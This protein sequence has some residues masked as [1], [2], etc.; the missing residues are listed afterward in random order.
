MKVVHFHAGRAS[1]GSTQAVVALHLALQRLG[2]DSRLA[3]EKL[4]PF[5]DIP[6]VIPFTTSRQSA[7]DQWVHE[8]YLQ[9]HIKDLDTWGFSLNASGKLPAAILEDADV[10]HLHSVSQS[11]DPAGIT[12]FLQSGKPVLWT[13]YDHWPMTGGCHSPVDC[14]GFE[15]SCG[16]CPRLGGDEFGLVEAS[17]KD[18]L[19]AFAEITVVAP[20]SWMAGEAR[21]SRIFREN[22]IESIALSVRSGAFSTTKTA[23]RLKHGIPEDSFVLLYTGRPSRHVDNCLEAIGQQMLEPREIPVPSI[24]LTVTQKGTGSRPSNKFKVQYFAEGPDLARIWELCGLADVF[25]FVPSEGCTQSEVLIS[26]ACGTPVCASDL[27]QAETMLEIPN[28]LLIRPEQLRAFSSSVD[29]RHLL[30]KACRVWIQE[31]HSDKTVAQQHLQLYTELLNAA[32]SRTPSLRS[33]RSH[34][35]DVLPEVIAK[36]AQ[37]LLADTESE[38]HAALAETTQELQVLRKQHS[39]LENEFKALKH[40]C[41][42]MRRNFGYRIWYGISFGLKAASRWLFVRNGSTAP[43]HFDATQPQIGL[44]VPCSV[45]LRAVAALLAAD[46]KSV[47]FLNPTRRNWELHKAFCQFGLSQLCLRDESLLEAIKTADF[48]SH[49]GQFQISDGTFGSALG[50]YDLIVIEAVADP[51]T[52]PLFKSHLWPHQRI[53]IHGSPAEIRKVF[54]GYGPNR[55]GADY[56]LYFA[57][58]VSWLDPRYQNYPACRAWKSG[59]KG[60]RL[61]TGNA[62]PRISIVTPS[63]NQGQF[64]SATIESVLTQ[65]YPDLEYLMLDGGSTDST[66]AVLAQ[67]RDQFAFCSSEKDRGQAH[68]INKGFVRSSGEIMAWLNSDD[69]YA[70]GALLRVA[71]TFDQF[72][73]ADLVVGGCGLLQTT[74]SKISNIHHS[75]L[76]LGQVMPL[77]LERLLDLDNCWLKGH[78]FYQPE[79]FWRRRAW[80]AVGGKISEDLYFSFDY[81]LWVRMAKSG[82]KIVHIPDLLA[83]YR[84]HPAQ[85]TFGSDLPYVPEL[86]RVNARVQQTALGSAPAPV[87]QH[88]LS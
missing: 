48:F 13:L 34:V 3:V 82:A 78:F 53:L 81:E 33:V 29:A 49:W 35:A 56:A 5:F 83:I 67:F 68:A 1:C 80:E 24:H 12:A 86:R 32:K 41:K 36:Q 77:P 10:I 17:F 75:S 66:P 45:E 51:A 31:N 42:R 52:W 84:V 73:E 64:I 9:P 69:Q 58:P 44:Q 57:P 71:A 54:P 85:K 76:P 27:S 7:V 70:P 46:A 6:G 50:G 16:N 25:L 79:V 22:R 59:R 11:L 37:T 60:L 62:Y 72:P 61:P 8:H 14:A 88:V 43:I 28:R 26:L 40:Q 47:F 87:I 15:D 4:R 2:V 39:A 55:E 18:R 21:K 38:H 23:L 20:N 63:F 19:N 30:T 65:E 74:D